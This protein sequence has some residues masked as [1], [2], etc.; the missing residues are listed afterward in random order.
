MVT[1]PGGSFLGDD[2]VVAWRVAKWLVCKAREQVNGY[3]GSFARNK[4]V[5]PR[6]WPEKHYVCGQNVHSELVGQAGQ[7]PGTSANRMVQ[8]EL[9]RFHYPFNGT[10]TS[11]A[12]V[13]PLR[14]RLL[15]LLH[16][17]LI[18]PFQLSRWIFKD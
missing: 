17:L 10:Q 11:H 3:A 15:L 18:R 16:S 2:N 6:F 1:R 14:L 12:T 5:W 8:C 7:W 9:S 4:Y 13:H